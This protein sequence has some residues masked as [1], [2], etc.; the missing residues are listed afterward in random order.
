MSIG[1]LFS[2]NLRNNKK[3][4]SFIA[5]LSCFFIVAFKYQHRN[6]YIVPAQASQYKTVIFD[7]GDVLFRT[8][9]RTKASIL[10]PTMF[11]NPTLLYKVIGMDIKEEFFKL[12][13]EIPAQSTQPM[14]NQSKKI[15]LIM[16]DWMTGRDINEIKD[17]V[18]KAIE[19]SSHSNSIKNLFRSIA[20]LMFD[21]QTLANSQAPINAMAK[22]AKNLKQK[23]YKLYVLSNWETDSYKLVRK[24]HP[25]LFN[26]FD[27]I[28][29]SGEEKMG[30]PNP[31]FYQK[32]LEKY[33]I[34]AD[35]CLFIDDEIN[36]TKAAQQL[37]IQ[38]IV[39]KN[40]AAVCKDFI[41]LGVMI[42]S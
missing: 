16:A 7:L 27:G 21:A 41:K 15:P 4:F 42:L 39:C 18:E 1:S 28:M 12:L 19:K 11:Q 17:L 23:G 6:M 14:Y 26:L 38:S 8:S 30:K 3:T 34:D 9:K 2:T 22:L 33:H 31:E 10:I 25:E 20:H 24:Q 40:T 35:Q 13:H 29:V 37:G 32:L 36:N 5:I